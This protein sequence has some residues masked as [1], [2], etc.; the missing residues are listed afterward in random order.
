MDQAI[1]EREPIII[2]R[3]GHPPVALI[4][5]DELNSMME[6][7]HL[8]RSPANARRIFDALD[9]LRSG[10]GVPMTIEELRREVGL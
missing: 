7:L 9:E 8:F 2:T 10:R 6:T 1:S 4:A 5:A 3:K